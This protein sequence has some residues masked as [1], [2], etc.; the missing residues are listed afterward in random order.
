MHSNLSRGLRFGIMMGS[1]RKRIPCERRVSLGEQERGRER[2]VECVASLCF[3]VGV[4]VCSKERS[5]Q[6]KEE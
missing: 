6:E 4:G 2:S 5:I 3:G 1:I